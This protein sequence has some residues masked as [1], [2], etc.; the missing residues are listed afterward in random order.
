MY[1]IMIWN[2]LLRRRSR[3]LIAL[4]A[5]AIG[6]TIVSG[7]VTIYYD[8]PRQMGRE[9]RSYGANLLFLPAGDQQSL[10]EKNLEQAAALLPPEQVV[11]IAPFLYD[12][13]KVNEQPVMVAGKI[14]RASCRERV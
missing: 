14:G 11:G 12:R 8:V 10:T 1:G 4:L 2:A 13:I 9:F 5:V 7:L 3:M 6:A